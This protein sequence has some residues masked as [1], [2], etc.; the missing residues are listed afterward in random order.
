MWSDKSKEEQNS[1]VREAYARMLVTRIITCL[2]I[3]FAIRS[4][5]A[6]YE[7][8]PVMHANTIYALF[9]VY[10]GLGIWFFYQLINIIILIAMCY[11]VSSK[12]I[13][14]IIEKRVRSIVRYIDDKKIT[15]YYLQG[16]FFRKYYLE[17]V[18][19]AR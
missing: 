16:P 7:R 10:I 19:N 1:L 9:T 8:A 4:I 12:T 18:P 17:E 14:R 3:A 11:V 6:I 13:A 15:A 2:I 5:F